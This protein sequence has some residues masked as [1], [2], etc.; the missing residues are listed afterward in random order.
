MKPKLLVTTSIEE[1][2]GLEHDIVFLGEWCK[3]YSRKHIW[4]H[5]SFDVCDYH[6]RDRAKLQVDHAYL[7]TLNEELLK[8]I[9][10]FLNKFHGVAKDSEYWRIIIGPWLLTYIP[11]LWDRWELLS[12]FKNHPQS[13]ETYSLAFGR[14][15][16]VSKDFSEAIRFFDSE[17][18]N[19]QIFLAILHH[20][21]DLN[22][23]IKPL[24]VEVKEDIYVPIYRLTAFK[25]LIRFALEII[26]HV[27]EIFS[28]RKRKFVF[29]Q[30][31]FPRLFLLKLNLSL[32]LLPRAEAY[33]EKKINYPNFI[34]RDHVG[35]LHHESS[36][37]TKKHDFENFVMEN[38]LLDIPVSYLEGY[39]ELLRIQSKFN[40][41]ENIFTANAHFGNELFKVWGAEQ[42]YK[43]SNLIISSHGGALYPLY[44]VF[45][46]Q[47]KISNFRVIW[48]L[49]WLSGQ[50]RMPANKLQD[51]VLDY[52][53]NGHISIIDYDGQK[54]SYRCVSIPMGPLSLDSYN[55]N[56]D[57]IQGLP[58]EIRKE[59]K[60][61]TFP[62]GAWER[63]DRY[64]DDLGID[65][66]SNN[67]L[68]DTI[69]NSRLVICT[70]PQTTFSEAMCSGVPTMILYNEQ[71]WEVQ[72]IYQELIKHLK[73]SGIM[74]TN[75]ILAANHV[76][77]IASDPMEWWSKPKT[78]L[79]RKM[80]NE[81]CLTIE[82]D[83]LNS[84]VELFR[85]IS[86]G[87]FNN[88]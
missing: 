15:R 60:I 3:R 65:I 38:I 21:N 79:A 52:N 34:K 58:Q 56:K 71:F 16:K 41:A 86:N 9:S 13:L 36:S 85:S 69:S 63:R 70:Y 1:S 55:L 11:V 78:I 54:Y 73:E 10:A 23:K 29:Y 2:W 76:A 25:K 12:H 4:Q 24:E 51:R 77:S 6:W 84:W 19:H 82:S 18:W 64:I 46:H 39:P 35:T 8:I 7:D 59:I 53:S 22:I 87:E 42:K 30:S 37:D 47:E 81:F 33:F 50:I 68:L 57:F 43:G 20:R 83:P 49:A 74:H 67:S 5:R 75:E 17:T 80:F 40:D 88:R 32:R 62:M 72:P 48:G 31:Y 14:N 44:T 28:P 45:N 66:I 27:I 26:D 61:R